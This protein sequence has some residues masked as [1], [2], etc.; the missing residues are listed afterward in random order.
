MVLNTTNDDGK[1]PVTVLSGFLGAG[2]T[3][4][5]KHILHTKHSETQPFRCAVIVNDM[6]ELNIDQSLVEQSSIVQSDEVV[7][8]QNGCVC[9]SLQNDVVE[10]ITK[11][12]ASKNFDYMLIEGSGV[13]EP[14]QIAKLFT[15]CEDDHD[16]ENA[17]ADTPMLGQVARLDTCVTV[18]DAS[19]MVEDKPLWLGP[20]QENLSQLLAEQIEYSNVVVLNKTDLVNDVQL[21]SIQDR[22]LLLNSKAKLIPCR[23][24]Q[25]PVM[26]VVDTRLYT[27]S[28][29]D[30]Q[31]TRFAGIFN[32][33][34]QEEPQGVALESCC[35]E[36]ESKGQDPCCA[37]ITIL[38][39][40]FQSDVSKVVLPVASETRHSARFGITSFVYRARRPFHPE[41]FGRGFLH[42]FFV[43][44]DAYD[45]DSE[46]LEDQASGNANGDE[47]EHND[48]AK[49]MEGE[50][51][52]SKRS[53]EELQ[54]MAYDRQKTR[55]EGLGQLIRAKGFLW[56]A[57]T[58]DLMTTFSHA[59]NLVTM[60]PGGV[61]T[62]LESKS[63]RGTKEEQSSLC[64][65]WVAPWGDRRQELVFIG[66][67]LNH[68]SIQTVLDECLL[69]DDEFAKGIDYWKA[70]MGDVILD[71]GTERAISP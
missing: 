13:S 43:Y 48:D 56:L 4:L 17:H 35:A 12:A 33:D 38:R 8:M 50:S 22:V 36:K 24:S 53:L 51:L 55:T 34:N 47:M 16:H 39:R 70:T 46:E 54:E 63:Y 23:N 20:S 29:F 27:P 71:I 25:I 67:N 59:G 60:T 57:D 21:Q 28:A 49:Q 66:K 18:V 32:E 2:K 26:E 15:D 9:C 62:A 58:H 69:S 68:Q 37:T 45:D 40:T 11:L 19:S 3:T 7:A 30:E 1:L 44:Y 64:K 41:R 10:Q 31:L 5:L 6:A 14:A 52:K 61:W 42:K 65:D